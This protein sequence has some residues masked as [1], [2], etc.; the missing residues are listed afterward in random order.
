MIKKKEM[1]V[2]IVSVFNMLVLL[3]FITT[4]SFAKHSSASK[5][6]TYLRLY[7]QIF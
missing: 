6:E 2:I 5:A 4:G 1:G 3:R 7:V